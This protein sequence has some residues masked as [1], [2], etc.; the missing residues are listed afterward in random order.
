MWEV[1][2]MGG[3]VTPGLHASTLFKVPRYERT[4]PDGSGH[5]CANTT[6]EVLVE[7]SNGYIRVTGHFTQK[8]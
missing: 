4:E 2:S 7:E 8:K 6:E 5:G 1:T 3:K